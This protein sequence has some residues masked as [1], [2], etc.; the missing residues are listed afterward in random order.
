VCT[1]YRWMNFNFGSYRADLT[2]LKSEFTR[3]L[4]N[5]LSVKIG[6]G[7]KKIRTALL[8]KTFISNIFGYGVYSMKYDG[9]YIFLYLCNVIYIV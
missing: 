9:I 3:F 1:E 2:L 6:K 8:S 7:Y 5:G 4:K